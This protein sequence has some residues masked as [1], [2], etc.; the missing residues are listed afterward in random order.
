MTPPTYLRTA[1]M[2]ALSLTTLSAPALAQTPQT[3]D[4]FEASLRT[5]TPQPQAATPRA[6]DGGRGNGRGGRG[7]RQGPASAPRPIAAPGVMPA[8]FRLMTRLDSETDGAIRLAVREGQLDPVAMME[9]LARPLPIPQDAVALRCRNDHDEVVYSLGVDGSPAYMA[10]LRAALASTETTAGTIVNGQVVASAGM[11]FVVE[12]EDLANSPTTRAARDRAVAHLAA[13]GFTRSGN[14]VA[15]RPV[16]R[17][18]Q[19][20]PGRTPVYIVFDN[21]PWHVEAACRRQN[22]RILYGPVMIV[23]YG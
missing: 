5:A 16:Y 23:R 3:P 19:A 12:R 22:V 1:L 11:R 8:S 7:A 10:A 21:D 9:H 2:V 20:W 17:P 4:D 14:D 13:S 18:G 15:G 6:T